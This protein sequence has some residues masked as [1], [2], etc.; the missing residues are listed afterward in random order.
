MLGELAGEE[1][2][3]FRELFGGVVGGVRRGL[4]RVITIVTTKIQVRAL[5]TSSKAYEEKNTGEPP[6]FSARPPSSL[7]LPK[8]ELSTAIR[9]T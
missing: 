5:H 2:E 7:L 1:M 4:W 6:R 9:D 3:V 8:E